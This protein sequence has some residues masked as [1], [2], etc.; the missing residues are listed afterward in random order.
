MC[1]L[2]RASPGVHNPG[3][4][5]ASNYK[6]QELPWFRNGYRCQAAERRR[7]LGR[8]PRLR[9]PPWFRRA[10]RLRDAAH[11]PDYV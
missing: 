10:S 7:H 11:R 9:G 6:R 2:R 5:A 3:A 1:I 8:R 4:Q